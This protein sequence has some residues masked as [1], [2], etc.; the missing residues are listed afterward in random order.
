MGA[1]IKWVIVALAVVGAV[2]LIALDKMTNEAGL[3]FV[4]GIAAVIGIPS[5]QWGETPLA[6]VVLEN[7]DDIDAETLRSWA[8]QR[9]G[10][11]QRIAELELREELPKSD[12]GK[13]LKREL[14]TPYWDE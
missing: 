3:I 13:V 1:N 14:R 12:I 10:K 6:L 2:V 4:A 8:N 9:L 5:P 7:A 11:G